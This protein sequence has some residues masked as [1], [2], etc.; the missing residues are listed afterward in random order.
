M[1][2]GGAASAWSGTGQPLP[3]EVW[4]YVGTAVAS[5]GALVWH[6]FDR[7]TENLTGQLIRTAP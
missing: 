3:D 7:A 1:L 5:G 4:R 6:V 2:R